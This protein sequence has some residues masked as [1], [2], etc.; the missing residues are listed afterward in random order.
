MALPDGSGII[1]SSICR[2][3]DVKTTEVL[4]HDRPDPFNF[5]STVSRRSRDDILWVTFV[6][7]VV[8]SPARVGD[9]FAVKVEIDYEFRIQ[10]RI[11]LGNEVRA[12]GCALGNPRYANEGLAFFV[13]K[14]GAKQLGNGDSCES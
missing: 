11:E 14:I 9:C 8:F 12:F 4:C 10:G 3:I 7:E 5:G 1:E 2:D 6:I 13:I